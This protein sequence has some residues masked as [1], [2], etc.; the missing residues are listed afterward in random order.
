LR[1]RFL[2]NVP[3]PRYTFAKTVALK[4]GIPLET[5]QIMLGHAKITTTQ[6]YADVDEEKVLDDTAGWQERL[7]KKREIVLASR[8]LQGAQAVRN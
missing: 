8:Q 7:D 3:H 4:N 1:H 2:S 6:I 5:V